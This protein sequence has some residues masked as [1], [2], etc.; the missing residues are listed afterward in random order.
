MTRDAQL[1]F[2]LERFTREAV[3][4]AAEAEHRTPGDLARLILTEWLE[5]KGYLDAPKKAPR[6]RG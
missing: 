6:R 5:A 4:R 2:R 1:T 3:D